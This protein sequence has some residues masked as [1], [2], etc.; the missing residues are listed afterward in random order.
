MDNF[1]FAMEK[2]II[3]NTSVPAINPINRK[4]NK[5]GTPNL[6]PAFPIIKL[7]K[8]KTEIIKRK[9]SKEIS[10]AYLFNKSFTNRGTPT[11]ALYGYG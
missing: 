6:Y 1:V 4:S 10:I 8:I 7:I 3:F 2:S 11:D 9:L 5:V